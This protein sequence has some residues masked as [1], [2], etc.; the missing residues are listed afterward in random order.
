ML[1]APDSISVE[2]VGVIATPADLA[3]FMNTTVDADD[4]AAAQALEMAT[5]QI[6]G[7]GSITNALFRAASVNAKWYL[8]S[9]FVA[10]R[11]QYWLRGASLDRL[12]SVVPVLRDG[13]GAQVHDAVSNTLAFDDAGAAVLQAE[14]NPPSAYEPSGRYVNVTWDVSALVP[15]TVKTAV[16][17]A[18]AWLYEKRDATG[19]SGTLYA[20][21]ER[22]LVRHS[23]DAAWK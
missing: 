2:P 5:D 6:E 9:Q 1:N 13:T 22:L 17:K 18:A 14:V 7:F 12:T 11:N 3:A 16:L 21:L 20:D 4:M 15:V 23:I 10:G 19:L 8:G